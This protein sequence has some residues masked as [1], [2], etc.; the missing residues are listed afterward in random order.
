MQPPYYDMPKEF[1]PS[2]STLNAWL[3]TR[4]SNDPNK[5]GIFETV[6]FSGDSVWTFVAAIIEA[7]AFFLTLF[8]FFRTLF[9]S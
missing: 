2:T 9:L 3:K 7:S 5:P 6:E 1:M 8:G 4:K